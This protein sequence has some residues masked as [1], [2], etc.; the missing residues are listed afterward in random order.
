MSDPIHPDFA[1]ANT[2]ALVPALLGITAAPWLPG[3]AMGARSTVLLVVDGLGWDAVAARRD[4]LATLGAME[5][6][7]ITTVVPSTTATVL[8]S[9][10]TGLPP[11]DHGIVGF[12]FPVDG[13]VL[14]A[15]R[16]HTDD[17]T[18]APNP[19]D[20]QR[21]PPFCNRVVPVVSKSEYRGTGFTRAHMR[22]AHYVG[23]STVAV[24]VE[25]IRRQ[26]SAGERLVYAYYPGV[27]SVAHEFGLHNEFYE[28]ELD[29]VDALI[30]RLLTVLPRDCALLVT[31]DHGQVDTSDPDAWIEVG[32]LAPLVAMSA[33]EAR[34]RQL[35]APKGAQ[36]ELLDAARAFAGDRA[37][38]FSRRELID[39]GW[40]GPEVA[41][42]VAGRI[43]D[44]VLAARAHFGFIDPAYPRES[45]LKSAHGS[46]TANEMLV[47]LLAARGRA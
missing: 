6:G 17:N 28:R 26:V 47:P 12:R 23:W 18:H 39:G 14:N 8:T 16:W 29:D 38:V 2:S 41:R 7:S 13:H 37:W 32:E 1:G 10:V 3:P 31:A 4:R 36:R 34:F 15:L 24:F 45:N 5:G 19:S 9:I 44:V 35:F 27:D 43:G 30:D 22:D 40:F 11:G 46:L 33:G 20:V 25:H 21:H 42:G